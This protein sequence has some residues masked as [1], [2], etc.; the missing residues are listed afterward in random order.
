MIERNNQGPNEITH[1]CF[2]NFSTIKITI[3][4]IKPKKSR[5]LVPLKSRLAHSPSLSLSALSQT[6]PPMDEHQR[7]LLLRS[8]ALF[9]LPAAFAPSYGTSGF[10][11]GAALLRSTVFRVGILAA[12]RALSERSVVGIMIT[13]SHNVVTDNGVK[14]ADPTGEMLAQEWEPFADS[15][16]NAPSSGDLVELIAE[17][18]QS[19]GIEFGRKVEV[20]IA[21]DTRPSGQSLLEAAK[22]VCGFVQSLCSCMYLRIFREMLEKYLGYR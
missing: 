22:V 2:V 10:R 3:L 20:L 21:R 15:L 4:P 14:I 5:T 19:E 11:A 1:F 6:N 16:A 13:A 8:A 17:F 9:P 18:T 12:L 7:S